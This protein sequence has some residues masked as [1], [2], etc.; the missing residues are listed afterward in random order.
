MVF[1][2]LWVG[3]SFGG[4][5]NRVR[6]IDFELLLALRQQRL[7]ERLEVFADDGAQRIHMTEVL[8]HLRLLDEEANA[9]AAD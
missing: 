6:C 2:F 8:L 5:F 4:V 3:H 7:L 9:L 1:D